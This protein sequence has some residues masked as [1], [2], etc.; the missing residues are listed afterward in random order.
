MRCESCGLD[1]EEGG[2]P[3]NRYET[4]TRIPGS[5]AGTKKV[6]V[7]YCDF[8]KNLLDNPVLKELEEE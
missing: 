2:S 3:I 8:C 5:M 4:V 7:Q 1:E 6:S